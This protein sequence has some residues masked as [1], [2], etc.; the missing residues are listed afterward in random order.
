MYIHAW[1][2]RST[3]NHLDFES[4]GVRSRRF[5]DIFFNPDDGAAETRHVFIEG[6]DLPERW[7]ANKDFV[8]VETGFGTGLN[9]L[10]TW[11]TW[12]SHV[13]AAAPGPQPRLRYYA[14]EAYPL[15]LKALQ[16][17]IERY[18]PFPDIAAQL[19]KA[20]P[21]PFS[22]CY[23]LS[24]D[25]DSVQLI[26]LFEPAL[27]ALTNLEHY[28]A[29]NE[30]GN[31]PSG[32]KV[33]AWFLDGFAPSVNKDMWSAE[34]FQHMAQYSHEH[35]TVASFTVARQVRDGLE[36]AGFAAHR[37]DGF[38]KKRHMLKARFEPGVPIQ[39]PAYSPTH[40]DQRKGRSPANPHYQCNAL[41]AANGTR[42]IAKTAVKT[43]LI[44]GAGIAGCCTAYQLARRG[45]QVT[46]LDRREYCASG[47]SGNRQAILY[48]RSSEPDS[49]LGAFHECC[50]HYAT[51][52]YR[53]LTAKNPTNTPRLQGMLQ[54]TPDSQP[55]YWVEGQEEIGTR[56]WLECNEA[57]EKAGVDLASDAI[58]FDNA[59]A[60]DPVSICQQ[61]I[62]HDNIR[63]VQA[64]IESLTPSKQ[65]TGSTTWQATAIDGRQFEASNV[66]ITGG[67]H[68]AALQQTQWLPLR[69]LRGQTTTIPATAA[70]EKLSLPICGKG[71]LTPPIPW[72]NDQSTFE[73]G[74]TYSPGSRRQAPD[75]ADNHENWSNVCALVAESSTASTYTQEAVANWPARVGFRCVTPDYLPV[76]GP[77]V[78]AEDFRERF[79]AL[80]KNAKKMPAERAQLQK[81]L[82][83]LSGLGSRGFGLAPFC[84]ELLASHLGGE[85]LPCNE[86]FRQAVHPARF[87]LRELKRQ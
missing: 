80:G 22:N 32:L 52:F 64:G 71:Y 1:T 21:D 55:P 24:F 87:L 75:G 43:V 33:D 85:P 28:T 37:C 78:D 61:L 68:S 76:V 13:E 20:W 48:A 18:N 44:I 2:N 72:S 8:I 46:L 62:D 77:V 65:E 15:T 51:R 27:D 10:S 81:G 30:L 86:Q 56:Q 11:H 49:L 69:A 59:G 47:A 53:S 35:T 14:I 66:V 31:A 23:V 38:G 34:L 50:S 74:A 39:Q 58:L 19:V 12:R 16:A 84:S 4:G 42:E 17:C 73:A 41:P 7:Q 67:E 83:I 3:K 70:F 63:F 6:N 40:G 54:L 79:Q 60:L 82:Y 26:L 5:G 29:C 45:W 57:S 25:N 9:F 36:A